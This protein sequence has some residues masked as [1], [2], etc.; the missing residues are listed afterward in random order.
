MTADEHNM[1]CNQCAKLYVLMQALQSTTLSNPEFEAAQPHLKIDGNII[2]HHFI[3]AL[4]QAAA[5]PIY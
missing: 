1:D 5:T 2:C 3:P 4:W